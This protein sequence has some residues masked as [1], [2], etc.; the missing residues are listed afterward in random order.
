MLIL[1]ILKESANAVYKNTSNIIGTIEG[2]EKFDRGAGGDISTKIDLI[3]EKSVFE[4]LKK[5]N[6]VPTVV[7]EECGLVK[8]NDDGLI[9]MDGIDGTTNANCGLPFYCC[10]LAY[11]PKDQLQYVTDAVVFNLFTGDVYYASKNKGS[12]VNSKK[13]ILKKPLKPIPEMVVGLNI[14]GLPE[15]LFLSISKL[16]SSFNHVRHLGANAL[17]LCYFAQG[18]IDIYIDIRNKI[19][20]IDMAACYLIA[21]EAGGFILDTS[22]NDL[23]CH[24]SVDTKMSFIAISN[25]E[26]FKWI[27]DLIK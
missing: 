3:A 17:E 9:V 12:F 14:S 21:K 11:S 26:Q 19:R 20:S 10:S 7:G 27:S 5:N 25:S 15:N 24:L 23:D 16:V 8:G 2:Q 18:S 1:D 13:L 22:G 4:T 6:F